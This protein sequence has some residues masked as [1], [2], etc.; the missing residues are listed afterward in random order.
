[1]SYFRRAFFPLEDAKTTGPATPSSTIGFCLHPAN[2]NVVGTA[3]K[4]GHHDLKTLLRL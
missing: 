2:K 1:M 4:R 3:Q